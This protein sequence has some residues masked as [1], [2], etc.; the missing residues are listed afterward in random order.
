MKDLYHPAAF[1]GYLFLTALPFILNGRFSNKLKNKSGILTKEFLK[2]GIP[3]SFLAIHFNIIL[4]IT[5]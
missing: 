2:F 4:Q 1:Y 3:V 5:D